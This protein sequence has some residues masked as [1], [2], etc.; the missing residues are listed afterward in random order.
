MEQSCPFAAPCWPSKEENRPWSDI[1]FSLRNLPVPAF[2]SRAQGV[3]IP[4]ARGRS[5]F[6]PPS[7]NLVRT[8]PIECYQVLRDSAA[9]LSRVATS[10][11]APNRSSEE[12][13]TLEHH[14]QP[15]LPPPRLK[16]PAES[17]RQP[18]G[19]ISRG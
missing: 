2:D 13:H 11:R 5:S 8:R 7:P 12:A 4:L 16:R 9:C 1:S 10:R 15:N 14:P 6:P 19:C 17:Q 18:V 3:S